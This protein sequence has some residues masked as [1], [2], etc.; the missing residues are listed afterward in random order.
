M[1]ALLKNKRGQGIMGMPFQ[2][3]FS[4]ILIAVFIYAAFTGIS[5]FLERADQAQLGKFVVELESKVNQVW[6][7]TE[8][9]Q[10]HVFTLPK[11]IELVCFGD[12]TKRVPEALCGDFE[13]FREQAKI[14][15]SNMFFCPPEGAYRLGTPVHFKIDC[16][17]NDCLEVSDA[18]LAC[19]V[20]E[21]KNLKLT[22]TKEFGNPKV[23]IGP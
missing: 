11:S 17:G 16:N 19:A 13:L 8:A 5:Y 6:Q 14:R 12:L 7:T 15:G 18:A 23:I 10:T 21:N 9:R 22:L 3:I 2:M 20:V 4:L 1:K